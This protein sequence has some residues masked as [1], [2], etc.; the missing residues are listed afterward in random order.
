M[1]DKEVKQY[2]EGEA[3]PVP[4]IEGTEVWCQPTSNP[5]GH[6]CCDCGFVH[7]V[8]W[9]MV[10]QD[11]EPVDI[12]NLQLQ[13][14]FKVNREETAKLREYKRSQAYD[15]PNMENVRLILSADVPEGTVTTFMGVNVDRFRKEDLVRMLAIIGHQR[16]QLHEGDKSRIVLLS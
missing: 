9:R 7:D 16:R 8:R 6:G 14:S 15:D 11:G 3:A 2:A 4:E 1:K 10:D 5:F 12:Q 13:L